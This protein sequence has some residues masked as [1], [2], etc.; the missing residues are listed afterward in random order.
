LTIHLDG[1]LGDAELIDALFDDPFGL[2]GRLAAIKV[3]G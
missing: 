1:R 3:G 2:L